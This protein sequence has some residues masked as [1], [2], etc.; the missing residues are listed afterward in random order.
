MILIRRWLVIIPVCV[1]SPQW[2]VVYLRMIHSQVINTHVYRTY[3]RNKW[4]VDGFKRVRKWF[5]LHRLNGNA[6]EK[7]L[8]ALFAISDGHEAMQTRWL[9]MQDYALAQRQITIYSFQKW[10]FDKCERR[11]KLVA[12]AAATGCAAW[13]QTTDS[14]LTLILIITTRIVFIW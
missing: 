11:G 5:G 8:L 10:S 12:A 1:A 2:Q 4:H 6:I 14:Q 9:L 7:Y 13:Q 3:K